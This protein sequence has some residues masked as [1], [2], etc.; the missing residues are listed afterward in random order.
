MLQKPCSQLLEQMTQKLSRKGGRM[1]IMMI[2]M[3]KG[4]AQKLM[5]MDYL[6]SSTNGSS[7]ATAAATYMV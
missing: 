2:W 5:Y 1:L 7:H 4:L 6:I 3:I